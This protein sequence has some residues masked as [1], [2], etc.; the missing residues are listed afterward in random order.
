MKILVVGNPVDGLQFYGPYETNDEAVDAADFHDSWCVADLNAPTVKS[1]PDKDFSG[2]HQFVN[3]MGAHYGSFEVFY[4]KA[5]AVNGYIDLAENDGWF[6]WAC[7]PG[8]LPD[9]EPAGPF[10]TAEGAYLDAI[11]D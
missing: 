5:D 1:E 10:P 11:G 7:F 2:Y 9:G 3:D 8:C 4:N 6:W